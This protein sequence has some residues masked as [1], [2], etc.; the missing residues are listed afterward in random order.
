MLEDNS[1]LRNPPPD[2]FTRAV[3][4]ARIHSSPKGR[5]EKNEI[6]SR[7]VKD[8]NFT[9]FCNNCLGGVFMHDAG[10]RFNSPTVNLAFDG[11]EFIKFLENPDKYLGG[12]FKF[13][14]CPQV[15]YPVADLEDI[16]IRF[17]HYKSEAECVEAWERRTKR[18]D[19]NNLF[20]IATDN[21]GMGRKDLLERFDKLPYDNKIMFTAQ[22]LPYK[23]AVCVPAFRGRKQV[24]I[25][26]QFA[27][28]KGTRYYE[29]CFDIASWIAERC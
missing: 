25:M 3:N 7:I 20:V 11:E 26:T 23:W 4:K 14:Q 27:D 1:I 28:F 15:D 6:I 13:K 16:E 12:Q 19:W 8:K 18:I 17:V 29:T 10:K 9:I 2:F 5:K 24:R 21:D 22:E